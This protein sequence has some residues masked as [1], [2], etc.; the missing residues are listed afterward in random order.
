MASKDLKLLIK[1]QESFEILEHLRDI[2]GNEELNNVWNNLLD[3]R[4][5]H[6]GQLK[7]NDKFGLFESIK[8]LNVKHNSTQ[9]D[10]VNTRVTSYYSEK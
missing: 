6:L 3:I 10:Y 8:L 2:T 9:S 1:I 4:N 5:N 7:T